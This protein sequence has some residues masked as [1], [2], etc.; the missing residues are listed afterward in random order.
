MPKT[1]P[2]LGLSCLLG[3]LS[4]LTCFSSPLRAETGTTLQGKIQ[5]KNEQRLLLSA[6]QAIMLALR[7]NRALRIEK[8]KLRMAEQ[9]LGREQGL[10]DL[11]LQANAE[12]NLENAQRQLGAQPDFVDILTSGDRYALSLSQRFVTGSA[13]EAEASTVY[14]NRNF[15]NNTT[16]QQISRLG[17]SFTQALLQGRDPAVNLAQLRRAELA[18]QLSAYELK[19]FAEALVADTETAFWDYI[20]ARQRLKLTR[21]SLQLARQQIKEAQLRLEAGRISQLDVLTF[22]AEEALREQ[23]RVEAENEL[24]R[25][26]LDLLQLTHPGQ[27]WSQYKIQVASSLGIPQVQ[28][29]SLDE[30]LQLALKQRPELLQARVQVQRG[31]L[32]LVRTRDGLLPRLDLFL[33]LGKTGYA[34]NFALSLANVAG[35]GYDL[36]AGFQLQYSLGNRQAE[37]NFKSAQW[38][39]QQQQ[40]ALYNLEQLVQ[41]DLRKA[42][43]E[44]KNVQAQI[45]AAQWSR[46]LQEQ[47]LEAEKERYS[48]GRST[49]FQLAIAQRD[50]LNS[51]L[52]EVDALINYMK[53]L[54]RF[55]RFEG[56]L[57]RRHGVQSR[58]LETIS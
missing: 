25:R 5:K 14:S 9:E 50:V 58:E 30:H 40:E 4:A 28:L 43:V 34:E 8:I 31:E 17:L 20:L 38:S 56:T 51:Q 53:S 27:D 6:D 18:S 57:L 52:S 48:V 42:F 12:K 22:K 1:K 44:L 29:N 24:V 45:R 47:K 41:L 32:E 54:T 15:A 3:L 55:Y 21:L 11:Q 7:N 13:I 10:F 23:A 26:R 35:N 46:Q 33:N 49:P 16:N 19:G 36:S 39:V 2:Y 37:A